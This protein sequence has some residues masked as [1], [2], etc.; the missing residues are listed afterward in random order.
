MGDRHL[1]YGCEFGAFETPGKVPRSPDGATHDGLLATPSEQSLCLIP[2]QCV[3]PPEA[4]HRQAATNPTRQRYSATH[5]LTAPTPRPSVLPAH[6][7]RLTTHP[8]RPLH[9]TRA[10]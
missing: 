3:G 10:P 8:D 4:H 6:L 1:G 9:P 7:P 2:K 5:R